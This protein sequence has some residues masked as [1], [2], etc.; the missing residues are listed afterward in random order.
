M[1]ISCT[2]NRTSDRFHSHE[3]IEGDWLEAFSRESVAERRGGGGI[4]A[5]EDDNRGGRF[6]ERGDAEVD[7]AGGFEGDARAGCSFVAQ[8]SVQ[9]RVRR[10][11]C[12]DFGGPGVG[13]ALMVADGQALS[14]VLV[15]V[16]GL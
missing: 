1:F 7:E 4:G 12:R 5:V 3:V 15:D 2:I 9:P 14:E 6:A 11:A 10:A 8:E 16:V 13:A